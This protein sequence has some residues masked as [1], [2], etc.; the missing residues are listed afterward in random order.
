VNSPPSDGA[1]ANNEAQE[2]IMTRKTPKEMVD[3]FE[4]DK[5]VQD[6]ICE[7][8]LC[9]DCGVNTHPGCPNGPQTRIDMALKGKS[10][11]EYGC[12]T[13]VYDVK[14]AIWKQ[15][16]MRAWNGCL[17]IGCLERRLGR[18]LRPRDFAH[19]DKTWASLPCTE[20]LLNRRGFATVTVRTAD[21]PKE[22]TCDI[23]D[24]PLL[25][26]KSFKVTEGGFEATE[27]GP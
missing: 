15:V 25:R 21:G 17:C 8:W 12:N 2:Q 11:V 5:A 14:D 26:G 6:N 20:R 4:K 7:S 1:G 22:I 9:V 3:S 10:T 13:E 19:S 23:K 18:Q 16:G 24:A 27:G